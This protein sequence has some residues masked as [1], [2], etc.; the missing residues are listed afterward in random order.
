MLIVNRKELKKKCNYEI[1]EIDDVY[2]GVYSVRNCKKRTEYIVTLDPDT[3]TCEA[4]IHYGNCKHINAVKEVEE[5]K[6]EERYKHIA[7]ED[8]RELMMLD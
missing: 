8:T 5:T 4:F 2:N 6:M 1:L 3:C 7:V